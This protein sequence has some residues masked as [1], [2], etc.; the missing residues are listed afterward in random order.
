MA[1]TDSIHLRVYNTKQFDISKLL[2]K[3]FVIKYKV[4]DKTG[5]TIHKYLF[6]VLQL[7]IS[8]DMEWAS[9][10]NM[11]IDDNIAYIYLFGIVQKFEEQIV[12]KIMAKEDE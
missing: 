3:D 2:K 12:D 11:N 1:S 9:V 4:L 7:Q 10:P 6:E 8:T 5:A